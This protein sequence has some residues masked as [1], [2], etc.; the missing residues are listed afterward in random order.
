MKAITAHDF[1]QGDEPP[2]DAALSGEELRAAFRRMRQLQ[3]E[4]QQQQAFLRRVNE[5]MS[6]AYEKLASMQETIRA[7]RLPIIRVWE[8]VLVA[9]LMGALD[10]ARA[11]ELS[12]DLLRAVAEGGSAFVVLDLTGVK[13]VD[14]ETPA[15]L[16]GIGQAVKLLG[17]S[18]VLAGL[19]PVAARMFVE[20]GIEVP[21]LLTFGDLHQALR[22]ALRRMGE[23]RGG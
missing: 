14:A 15:H 1:F 22:H 9:P 12:A 3:R 6:E 23:L 18:C 17:A 19:S 10:R 21:E 13:E 5:S 8:D 7:L 2:E 11:A 20:G 4:S 16:R